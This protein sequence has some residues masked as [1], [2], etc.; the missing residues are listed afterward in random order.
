MSNLDK[1]EKSAN[2]IKSILVVLTTLFAITGSIVGGYG[3]IDNKFAHAEDVEKLEK[4]ITLAELKTSL[5]TA[6]EELYFLKDQFRKYPE[7]LE[8]QERL[9]EAQEFVKSLKEQ[10]KKKLEEEG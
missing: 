7:D 2:S 9:T 6:L 1:A 3:F 4:R 10:I 5:R 8:I